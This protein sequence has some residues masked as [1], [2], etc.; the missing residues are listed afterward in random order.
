VK[1]N[2]SDTSK[3]L[4]LV[5]SRTKGRCAKDSRTPISG[6]LDESK[7]ESE[8]SFTSILTAGKGHR[9]VVMPTGSV[10]EVSK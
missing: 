5:P 4:A 7:K 6:S 3:T 2:W 10:G 9:V 8:Q 1:L